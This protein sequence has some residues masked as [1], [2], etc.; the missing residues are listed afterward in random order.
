MPRLQVV[1]RDIS[2]PQIAF[3]ASSESCMDLVCSPQTY[4]FVYAQLPSPPSSSPPR[5]D[6][7]MRSP[8]GSLTDVG[9]VSKDSQTTLREAYRLFCSRMYPNIVPH[10]DLE[11]VTLA[12]RE[13]NPIRDGSDFHA[14]MQRHIKAQKNKL[15]LHEATALLDEKVDTP[16][17]TGVSVSLQLM[18]ILPV[19]NEIG[20]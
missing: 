19:T 18:T 5:P 9:T 1:V 4:L 16:V 14:F 11:L 3:N 17:F 7:S 20:R 8:T 2:L 12:S 13:Y 6:T 15:G 10:N